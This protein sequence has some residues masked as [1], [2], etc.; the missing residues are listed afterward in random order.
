MN[1]IEKI[2]IGIVGAAGRGGS[3]HRSIEAIGSLRLH[4][5]CD[6][7]AEA[8]ERADWLQGVRKFSDFDKM[9][10][11]HDLDALV[12]GTPMPLHVPQ[13]IAALKRGR[14]IISEVT[15]AISIAESK[16]LVAATKASKG[17]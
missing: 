3:F 15:A 9:L 1:T 16:E 12:I 5:V 10:E 6:L 2:N 8:L 13:S 14:H 7:N 11:D 4:S 17:I